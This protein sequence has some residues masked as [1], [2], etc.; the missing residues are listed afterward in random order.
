MLESAVEQS[1]DGIAVSELNGNISFVNQAWA[2]MHGYEPEEISRMNMDNFY[3][4]EQLKNELSSFK[5]NTVEKN[6]EFIKN[7]NEIGITTWC[8]SLE[9]QS[10]R[11]I[12][13][14]WGR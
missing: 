8:K 14:V 1:V 2:E 4:D 7:C 11:K 12:R 10:C 6:A 3:T 5:K 13:E 9:E